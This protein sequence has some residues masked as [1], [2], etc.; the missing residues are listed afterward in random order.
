MKGVQTGETNWKSNCPKP[1]EAEQKQRRTAF[2]E[3]MQNSVLS[4][5]GQSG[6]HEAESMRMCIR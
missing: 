1:A 6:L 3:Q 5:Y 4:I 2:Q